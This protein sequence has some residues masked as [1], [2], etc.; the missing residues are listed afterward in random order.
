M[1]DSGGDAS[2]SAFR[3]IKQQQT[4]ETFYDAWAVAGGG[5]VLATT[6]CQP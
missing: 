5:G 3:S 4:L 6:A 1:V 2:I